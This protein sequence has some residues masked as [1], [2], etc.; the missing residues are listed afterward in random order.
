MHWIQT[1]I[2]TYKVLLTTQPS[3]L[4]HLI[5]VHSVQPPHSTRTSSLVTLARPP[6]SGSSRITDRYFRYALPC[7]WNQLPPSFRQ[8]HLSSD[9]FLPSLLLPL[10]NLLSRHR[11]PYIASVVTCERA[12]NGESC[13]CARAAGLLGEYV[14]QTGMARS[15]AG[16]HADPPQDTQGAAGRGKLGQDLDTG[17]VL[18]Q[19]EA[20]NVSRSHRQQPAAATER[21]RIPVV[22]HKVSSS[23]CVVAYD[24]SIGPVSK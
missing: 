1:A 10:L 17:H 14:R 4:H 24:I 21:H 11:Y 23:R 5:I 2:L 22:R 3:Y 13:A 15:P 19:R 9:S 6:A 8:P 12:F 18:S 7:L 20:R 16:V